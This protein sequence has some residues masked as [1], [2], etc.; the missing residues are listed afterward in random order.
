MSD[1][2]VPDRTLIED[3]LVTFGLF[4]ANAGQ[5]REGNEH[6]RGKHAHGQVPAKSI[7]NQTRTRLVMIKRISKH[8]VGLSI[9]SLECWITLSSLIHTV[10]LSQYSKR[11]QAV[12][13]A[14]LRRGVG[15]AKPH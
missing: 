12:G 15:I 6:C 7:W 14:K 5:H 3:W 2:K 11:A 10:L 8:K 9:V 4:A 13:R 1:N